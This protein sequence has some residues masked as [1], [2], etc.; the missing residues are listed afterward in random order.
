[1]TDIPIAKNK[2][3]DQ[4]KKINICNKKIKCL[5]NNYKYMLINLMQS[6]NS[7]I[8]ISHHHKQIKKSNALK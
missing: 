7:Q 8:K 1:M 5:K 2:I 4:K 6:I 3:T